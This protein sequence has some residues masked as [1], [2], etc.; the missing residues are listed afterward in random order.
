MIISA[1]YRTA[2]DILHLNFW[3]F[4]LRALFI[5]IGALAFTALAVIILCVYLS[6]AFSNDVLTSN[7]Y[8]YGII[9]T[10]EKWEVLPYLYGSIW[11]FVIVSIGI[12][13]VFLFPVFLTSISSM[14]ADAIADVVEKNKGYTTGNTVS[15]KTGMLSM[16]RLMTTLIMVNIFMIPIYVF[17]GFIG[18]IMG[19]LVSGYF[20]GREYFEMVGG[21]YLNRKEMKIFRKQNFGVVVCMGVFF[22]VLSSVPFLNLILPVI[23]VHFVTHFYGTGS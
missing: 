18:V 13:T 10:F 2:C 23:M 3:G 5:T 11:G 9:N 4:V 17:F 16:I 21:R 20:F 7:S 19:V 8:V 12:G 6:S 1:F 15:I 22:I 14:Y